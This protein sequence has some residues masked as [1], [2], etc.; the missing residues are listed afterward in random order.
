ML[1]AYRSPTADPG[2]RERIRAALRH[3]ADVPQQIAAA[4]ARVAE[5]AADVAARGNPNLLG[6]AHAAVLVAE[7]ATRAAANLVRINVELG[8]LDASVNAAAQA[9]VT[10]AATAAAGFR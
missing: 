3:A 8:G 4:G 5:L 1:A 6:D 10:A 9:H 2:R 7:A